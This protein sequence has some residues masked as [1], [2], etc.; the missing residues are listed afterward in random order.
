VT[1]TP[2]DFIDRFDGDVLKEAGRIVAKHVAERAKMARDF[3]SER[4]VLILAGHEF[5]AL[6]YVLMTDGA[7]ENTGTGERDADISDAIS[8]GV[9]KFDRCL[10]FSVGTVLHMM[11]NFFGQRTDSPS[12]AAASAN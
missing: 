12:D 2:Q 5:A 1:D 10:I 9:V 11:H 3:G 7:A 6:V 8:R 4:P